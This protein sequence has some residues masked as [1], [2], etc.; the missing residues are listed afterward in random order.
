MIVEE[1][2]KRGI[3]VQKSSQL[4]RGYNTSDKGPYVVK[5]GSRITPDKG[6]YFLEK[7]DGKVFPCTDQV[8][9]VLSGTE[10]V[11]KRLGN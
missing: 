2:A 7:Q 11:G 8:V 1:L 3:T 9:C 5:A 10:Y 4:F 6:I